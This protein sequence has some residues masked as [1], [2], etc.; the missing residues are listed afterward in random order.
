MSAP[1]DLSA[2]GVV[3]LSYRLRSG[4]PYDTFDDA[5]AWEGVVRGW[6]CRLDRDRLQAIPPQPVSDLTSARAALEPA[7][8]DW[9]ASAL[10][11]GQYRIAFV[12]DGSVSTGS[13]G[14]RFV[15][16]IE[17]DN[18]FSVDE[19]LIYRRANEAYPRPDS[20]F[21]KDATV[22]GLIE[23]IEVFWQGETPL[24]VAVSSFMA[25]LNRGAGDRRPAEAWNIDPLVLDTLRELAERP[26]TAN[27]VG[28]TLP[29]YRGP[30]WQWMQEALMRVAHHAGRAAHGLPADLL[31][32][33]SF[34]TKL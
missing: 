23:E 32:M 21:S 2:T 27:Q 12:F 8:R 18:Q 15:P 16:A 3:K 4:N 5:P 33:E 9:E 20:S 22:S 25:A 11:T 1:D 17:E 6:S 13:A 29:A 26:G 7:L 30:E 28:S 19:D 31:T 10:L 24:P 14:E 34:S